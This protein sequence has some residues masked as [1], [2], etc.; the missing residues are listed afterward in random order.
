MARDRQL[1]RWSNGAK[2]AT[3]STNSPKW[4]DAK[5]ARVDT[6]MPGHISSRVIGV[7]LCVLASACASDKEASS[8]KTVPP[9]P[10]PPTATAPTP[11]AAPRAPASSDA[12]GCAAGSRC[13]S[14]TDTGRPSPSG[15]SVA[16]CRGQFA[17]FIV[18]KNTIPSNYAG[19]WF[20]PELIENATTNGPSE[21]RPWINFNPTVVSGRLPYL[22]ALRNYAFTGRD[23]RAFTPQLTADSNYLDAAGGGVTQTLRAQSW[24]PAPRMTYGNPAD[25]GTR[26][27]ARGMTLERLVARGE[28]ARNTRRFANYAVAYYDARGAHPYQQV[29]STATPGRDTANTSAMQI[30]EGALVYKLLFSAARSSD[31]SQ[32]ILQGSVAANLLPNAGGPAA[33]VRLL[34]IDIAVKDN[35][36]QRFFGTGPV[37]GGQ[38]DLTACA[39]YRGQQVSLYCRDY[40]EIVLISPRTERRHDPLLIFD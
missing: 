19:P 21:T 30:P 37:I 32:D 6:A 2:M 14:V 24:Y 33:P 18:P 4:R 12:T 25:P 7:V 15:T 10:P 8:A 31:F 38:V 39:N 29:W 34:Q 22:L 40:H 23:L 20:Q 1:D 16:Q 5:S 27:A 13:I 26:E 3:T 11:P 9:A 36:L 17:D 35:T 28:L